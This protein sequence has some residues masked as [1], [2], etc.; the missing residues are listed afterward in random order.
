MFGE[1]GNIQEAFI[2]ALEASIVER[3]ANVCDT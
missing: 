3:K 2:S 1:N